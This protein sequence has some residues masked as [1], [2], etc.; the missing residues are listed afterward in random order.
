MCDCAETYRVEARVV[1]VYVVGELADDFDKVETA[2]TNRPPG[3]CV[4]DLQ[5]SGHLVAGLCLAAETQRTFLRSICMH[6]I[7]VDAISGR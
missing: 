6:A 3:A 2:I 7:Q 4:K 5:D 1:V